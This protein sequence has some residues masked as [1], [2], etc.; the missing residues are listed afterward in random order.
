MSN[1]SVIAQVPRAPEQ[2]IAH[3]FPHIHTRMSVCSIDSSALD[4][5]FVAV[6]YS[7]CFDFGWEKSTALKGEQTHHT[8]YF[9]PNKHPPLSHSIFFLL[10][11]SYF[12]IMFLP[13]A[14]SPNMLFS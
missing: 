1:L 7:L 10:L 12:L 2:E 9:L 14:F 13:P 4:A 6:K 5:D 8:N 11:F 3:S